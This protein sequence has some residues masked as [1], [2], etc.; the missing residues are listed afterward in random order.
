MC[1]PDAMC[2][3]ASA[4]CVEVFSCPSVSDVQFC[5]SLSAALSDMVQSNKKG[6]SN[7]SS[8]ARQAAVDDQFF[9][10]MFLRE[11]RLQFEAALGWP[12]A[13]D[14]DAP[15][16]HAP[17]L[18]EVTSLVSSLL[19]ADLPSPLV[20]S[21][22][23]LSFETRK[24]A[25]WLV[26][27]FLRCGTIVPELYGS[28]V[29]YFIAHP[30]M[31][32]CI[33]QGCWDADVGCVCAHLFRECARHSELAEVFLSD[34]RA[35]V[36]L[37]AA[38]RD[39]NFDVACEAFASLRELLLEQKSVAARH[40]QAHYSEFITIYKGLLQEPD[41]VRRRL[42][43]ALIGDM[44]LD[45]SFSEVMLRY[46]RDDDL[47]RLHMDLLLDPSPKVQLATFH[48][49]KLFIANP[50]KPPQAETILRRNI[51][52]LCK[53]IAKLPALREEDDD[54]KDDVEAVLKMLCALPAARLAARDASRRV[55]I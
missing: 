43:L 19:Q 36:E 32:R 16:A 27:A 29:G 55:T 8:S 33:V 24:D 54:L 39:R 11:I 34:W 53:R 28:I 37:I 13:K 30:D 20:Q 26:V 1:P 7:T 14:K 41:Y 2:P 18:E 10:G 46:V 23:F 42:A 49:L 51:S 12:E 3:P 25:M 50:A 9:L 48:V 52:G 35:E 31:L 6:H 17:Q 5:R 47:L 22:C 4:S 44:L 21:L 38:A 15:G 40:I 45:V